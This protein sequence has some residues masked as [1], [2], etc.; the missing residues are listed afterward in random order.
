MNDIRLVRSLLL[1][2]CVMSGCVATPEAPTPSST[3]PLRRAFTLRDR[4]VANTESLI[5]L[6]DSYR[7]LV[8]LIGRGDASQRLWDARSK[9]EAIRRQIAS[10]LPV[11]Q[12]LLASSLR[13]LEEFERLLVLDE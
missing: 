6:V 11:D 12:R 7:V 9:L 1:T 10:D 8:D 3:C 13:D 5:V 4:L 2:L